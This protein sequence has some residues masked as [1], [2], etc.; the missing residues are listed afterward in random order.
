MS[1]NAASNVYT[2]PYEVSWKYSINRTNIWTSENSNF[3]IAHKFRFQFFNRNFVCYLQQN[4]IA[5]P[6][7]YEFAPGM[8]AVMDVDDSIIPTGQ[9]TYQHVQVKNNMKLSRKY[10]F[11]SNPRNAIYSQIFSWQ[12]KFNIFSK[13]NS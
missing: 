1:F 5:D 13:N 3:P 11:P 8:V 2:I 6:Q 12:I 7:E 4:W 10:S 9:I